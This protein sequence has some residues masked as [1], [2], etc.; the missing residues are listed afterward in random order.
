M[1][2]RV[3]GSSGAFDRG[4][5][6]AKKLVTAFLLVT[7]LHS[8][9]PG[10]QWAQEKEAATF[11][12]EVNMVL[13][14]V[15]VTDRKGNYVSGLKPWD[16]EIYEDDLKQTLA[17]FA[18]GNQIP[19]RI[20]EFAETSSKPQLVPPF[21]MKQHPHVPA[22]STL[23]SPQD[24]PTDGL[25]GLI[26]GASVFILFD[27]SNY[28][29]R[30]F[31][32][33]Q[34]AISDFIR[35]LDRPD[36]VA[37]YSFSRDMKRVAP[38]T[39]DRQEVLSALRSTVAGDDVA[40]YNALLLTLRDAAKL[41][42]RKVIVVFSNGPDNASMVAP[43]SVREV[44]QAEGIPIYMISTHEAMHD[45][46]STAVFTR[47]SASTGGKAY[48]ARGWQQQQ[49]AFNL[50]RE[51]L[52]HLYLLSYYPQANANHG[53]RRITVKMVGNEMKNFQTRTRTGYRPSSA[54]IS[55]DLEITDR[56][57]TL[58]P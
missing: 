56:Q 34:D 5:F 53:W 11:R 29:Y 33:A 45:P 14:N 3:I 49:R 55:G 10:F 42:G 39:L 31:V 32:F 22:S 40:L 6:M 9:R 20:T 4:S 8:F 46:I 41:S 17:T 44:A 35:F 16:F 27:T 7:I 23:V 43:E 19:R 26:A 38:A 51:E 15:A 58:S 21:S 50:I 24:Q 30:S 25:S 1:F 47:M 28:M 13:L 52:A 12:V 54:R 2:Q 36:R 18:E 48:F 37:V 57:K